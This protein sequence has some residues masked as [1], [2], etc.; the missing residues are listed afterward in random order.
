VGAVAGA[1]EELAE[2]A[3]REALDLVDRI[4]SEHGVQASGGHL[5]GVGPPAAM[6]AQLA[7]GA[8]SALLVAGSRGRGPAASLTLGSVTQ[9]LATAAPCP[10]V[11]VPPGVA[12][13][14]Y[15]AR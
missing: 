6:L 7:A 13:W 5:A 4:A 15:A 10:L 9:E 11:V 3:R 2:D 8:G 1:A 14:T 12:E